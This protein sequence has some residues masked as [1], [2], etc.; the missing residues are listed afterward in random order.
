M[1]VNCQL[2]FV[3][4]WHFL[5]YKN[6]NVAIKIVQR[7]ETAEEI[8]KK[9]GRFAREVAMLSRVQHKNLVKVIGIYCKDELMFVTCVIL[10]CSFKLL[11]EFVC[12]CVLVGY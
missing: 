7:G 3:F 6:Q 4:S 5:R 1:I 11:S 12:V 9:E 10:N 8:A 2:K